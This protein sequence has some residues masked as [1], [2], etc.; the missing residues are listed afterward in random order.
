MKNKALQNLL[1][2]FTP[3]LW[4]IT[5]IVLGLFIGIMALICAVLV[6]KNFTQEIQPNTDTSEN[7][8]FIKLAQKL[9]AKIRTPISI[10]KL[11]I[12]LLTMIFCLSVSLIGFLY[13][14]SVTSL[15]I[16]AYQ[17]GM[18]QTN[19]NI[20]DIQKAI[21]A[22][23]I[24]SKLPN[25]LKNNLIIYYKFG[26]HD[27]ES[28]YNELSD[29]LKNTQVYWIS[30]KSNTGKKLLDKYPV[31]DVPAGLYITNNNTGVTKT[32]S[33]SINNQTILDL[34]NLNYLLDLKE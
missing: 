25:D 34:D 5:A 7:I 31:S 30:V 3:N 29:T 1:L 24:Q 13:T 23:P 4:L 26:C 10:Y 11:T 22:S 20:K 6:Y 16:T 21:N 12:Y 15:A 9:H 18:Y 19:L 32:L 2:S 33:K 14:A 27:C 17:H 28:I 8:K